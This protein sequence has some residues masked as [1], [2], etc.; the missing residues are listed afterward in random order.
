M[1]ILLLSIIL[2]S[3]ENSFLISF[4]H[5]LSCESKFLEFLT[6]VN[7]VYSFDSRQKRPPHFSSRSILIFFCQGDTQFYLWLKKSWPSYIFSLLGLLVVALSTFFLNSKWNI[8]T[9]RNKNQAEMSTWQS[10][11]WNEYEAASMW[12]LQPCETT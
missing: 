11:R 8:A 12:Q 4:F 2:E 6:V 9:K 3:T 1:I 10:A 7:D 5:V